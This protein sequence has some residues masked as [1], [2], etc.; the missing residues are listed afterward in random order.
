[1]NI[2]LIATTAALIQG[3]RRDH[4]QLAVVRQRLEATAN[5]A[6]RLAPLKAS[7]RT[8][9][10]RVRRSHRLKR[11]SQQVVGMVRTL[12]GCREI[13][14][15]AKRGT[16]AIVDAFG[17]RGA[18]LWTLDEAPALLA[19]AGEG[20]ATQAAVGEVAQPNLCGRMLFDDDREPVAHLVVDFGGDR[21]SKVGFDAYVAVLGVVLGA[22]R[23]HSRSEAGDGRDGW[24]SYRP[25]PHRD[26][27]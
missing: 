14:E 25:A 18:A 26:A 12:A 10:R 4:R 2:V 1:L 6:A 9:R 7:L 5:D 23:S 27:A 21:G 22:C 13:S 19:V 16:R 15:T 17:V 24:E 20:P 11:R 3:W 8:E